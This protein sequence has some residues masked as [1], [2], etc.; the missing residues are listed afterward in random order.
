VVTI[1]L[2]DAEQRILDE[3]EYI[4]EAMY[5]RGIRRYMDFNS[6]LVGI[7]RGISW[8]SLRES[9]YIPGRSGVHVEQMPS[10]E[11]VRRIAKHLE[12]AGLIKILSSSKRLIFECV[13]AS[14]GQSVQN[15]ADTK[16]TP[17]NNIEA[18]TSEP[19]NIVPFPIVP[20]ITNTKA[21]TEA[22]ISKNAQADTPLISDKIHSRVWA[23]QYAD[24]YIPDSTGIWEAL[25]IDRGL[26][27]HK[28]KTP[29]VITMLKTWVE[30]KLSIAQAKIAFDCAEARIGEVPLSAM[31]YDSFVKQT[32]N[33]ERKRLLEMHSRGGERATNR[34]DHRQKGDSITRTLESCFEAY[35]E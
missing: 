9:L 5:R 22:D 1:C 19:A 15:K 30:M 11:Q 8:Q 18:D 12:R 31:Y 32:L 13:L 3:L 10:K 35:R 21:D 25:L 29:Q 33:E 17:Q 34:R 4:H 6:G 2:N 24:D 20:R 16:P 28:I 26:L 14:R 27:F 7:K 23:Y